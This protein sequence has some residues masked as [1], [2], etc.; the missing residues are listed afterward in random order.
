LK[1]VHVITRL[2]VGGAQENTLLT[3]RGLAERGH[4]VILAAGQ[5]TGPEGSLWNETKDGGF[6]T[7]VIP[8]LRRAVRPV[9]DMLAYRT[10]KSM[11]VERKPKIVHT[12]S[13]KAGILARAAA[14]AAGI[15]IL[16]HTIHGMSFNRTQ[17]H[18]VQFAYR[19]LERHVAGYTDRFVCVADAMTEQAVV[20]G[21]APRDRFLTIRS[22]METEKFRPD[23][24]TR[25]C[26]RRNLGYS[27]DDFVVGT[28]ARL[29][30]HKGFEE[31]L[32][33]MPRLA[34]GNP[35]LRFL[36]VG[37]GPHRGD[38]ERAL[39]RMKLRDRVVFTGLLPPDRIPAVLCG[40]DLL[41][42]A[43]AWEGLPRAAVQ[44]LLTEVAVVS[45]DNDG[46]PEVVVDGKTGILVPLGDTTRLAHGIA[47]LAEN[48][49]IRWELGREG[50]RRCLKEFDWRNMV[51]R[52]EHLYAEIARE[53]NMDS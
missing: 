18:L 14:R 1:I 5:E 11:F 32:A 47:Y 26:V 24:V 16:V 13:S 49:E 46:A 25:A 45:F 35:K 51:E 29:F 19:R 22:G 48:P 38:Y 8:R 37:D 10:L 30:V 27:D 40:I 6:E 17:T 12:H 28:V 44:A 41:V 52:L 20:A 3:C 39:L 23:P 15:P 53:R 4:E 36:W 43:S 34:A 2:I 33:V 50:R 31:L 42:H 21:L 7:I 9:D